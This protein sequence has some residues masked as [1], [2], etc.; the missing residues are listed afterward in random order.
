M[1]D[2]SDEEDSKVGAVG[3]NTSPI[4][5]TSVLM[6]HFPF[7]PKSSGPGALA[8]SAPSVPPGQHRLQSSYCL[9]H[10]KKADTK[11]RPQNFDASLKQVGKFS[12]AEQFWSL[13]CHLERPG[14]LPPHSDYHLFKE[15]IKP[16]WEVRWSS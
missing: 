6:F 9:W 13:Y 3:G 10:S 14:N 16:M 15:G 8:L 1:S 12:S 5:Q 4:N 7:Q 2:D 11:T